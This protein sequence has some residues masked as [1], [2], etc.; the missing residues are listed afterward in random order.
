[1]KA[2]GAEQGLYKF[3]WKIKRKE[4]NSQHQTGTHII[5]KS[6]AEAVVTNTNPRAWMLNSYS[7][8]PE[9]ME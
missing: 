5:A 3:L 7:E 1:M 6:K 8:C 2:H 4:E 9:R